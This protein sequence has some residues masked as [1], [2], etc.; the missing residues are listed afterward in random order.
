M[1]NGPVCAMVWEGKYAVQVGRTIIGATFPV[2]AEPTSVRGNY[3]RVCDSGFMVPQIS[4]Q[5]NRT[6]AAT[7]ATDPIR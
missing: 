4:S 6:S 7:F 3:A 5:A 2:D 1:S